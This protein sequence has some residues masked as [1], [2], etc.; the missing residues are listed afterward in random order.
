MNKKIYEVVISI[1]ENA[2]MSGHALTWNEICEDGRNMMKNALCHDLNEASIVAIFEHVKSL[3]WE[4]N[5]AS[6]LNAMFGKDDKS[7]SRAD[8]YATV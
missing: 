4:I 6:M 5:H 2:K 7:P 8:E 3:I 1:L